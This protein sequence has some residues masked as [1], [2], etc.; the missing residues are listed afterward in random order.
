M[1][2]NEQ[3]TNLLYKKHM[4]YGDTRSSKEIFEETYRSYSKVYQ[5]KVLAYGNLIPT[6]DDPTLPVTI[7]QVKALTYANP[8]IHYD[9]SKI[10][11]FDLIKKCFKV[12]FTQISPNCDDAFVLLDES[13]KQIENVIPFDLF[14]DAYNYKLEDAD[15]NEI[16]YGLNDWSFDIDSSILTFYNGVPDNVSADKPPLFTFYQYVGPTGQKSYIDALFLDETATLQRGQ[17]V[18]DVTSQIKEFL[19]TNI[20]ETWFDDNGFNGGDT[21]EGLGLSFNKITPIVDA[22]TNDPIN[23]YD[24]RSNT[25]VVTLLSHITGTADG[26]SV[27]F[28]SEGLNGSTYTVSLE[29]GTHLYQFDHH[30]AVI[31]SETSQEATVEFSEGDAIK[32]VTLVKNLDTGDYDLYSTRDEKTIVFKFPVFVDLMRLPPSL[33]LND[34]NSYSDSLTPQYYGPRVKDVVIADDS[35]SIDNR[36]ADYIVYDT[37][38]STVSTVLEKADANARTFYLRN[39]TYTLGKLPSLDR[40]YV[41]EGESQNAVISAGTIDTSDFGSD[42]EIS[43][44]N[45]TFKEDV[46]INVS[47]SKVSFVNC[48]F[49]GNIVTDKEATVIVSHSI[50]AGYLEAND[51]TLT[52]DGGT[53]I[54]KLIFNG[55]EKGLLSVSDADIS[56]LLI[57]DPVVDGCIIDSTR[58][59]RVESKPKNVKLESSYVVEYSSNVDTTEIPNDQTL[60]FYRSFKERVY[61]KFQAPYHYDTD[62]NTFGLLIDTKYHTLFIDEETGE[63]RSRFYTDE[64]TSVT[65]TIKTQYQDHYNDHQ[66]TTL[67]LTDESG[68]YILNDNGNKI[69]RDPKNVKEAIEDL[70]WAKADLKN[71]KVPLQ[72]LPDSVAYGGLHF[73]GIW[74]F[75]QELSDDGETYNPGSYPTFADVDNRYSEDQEVDELQPGWFFIVD[76]SHDADHK[77]KDQVAVLQSG[78]TEP[79]VFTAGDWV[80]WDGAKWT[81]VDRAFQEVVYHLLP[82]LAPESKKWSYKDGGEGY[83]DFE[84]KTIYETIDLLN[85]AL[86]AFANHV[87]N[88]ITSISIDNITSGDKVAYNELK[89]DTTTYVDSISHLAYD[90]DKMSE[91]HFQSHRGSIEPFENCFYIGATY[92]EPIVAVDNVDG[93]LVAFNLDKFNPFTKWNVAVQGE[94]EGDIAAQFTIDVTGLSLDEGTYTKTIAKTVSVTWSVTSPDILPNGHTK[95]YYSGTTVDKD[96]QIEYRKFYRLDKVEFA[97]NGNGNADAIRSLLKTSQGISY[98]ESKPI[99]V[100]GEVSVKNAFGYGSVPAVTSLL[101]LFTVWSDNEDVSDISVTRVSLSKGTGDYVD[102]NVTWTATLTP[103]SK[104]KLYDKID[105][106]IKEA[107]FYDDVAECD[108]PIYEIRHIQFISSSLVDNAWDREP[109]GRVNAGYSPAPYL[110][111][112]SSVAETMTFGQDFDYTALVSDTAKGYELLYD[113]L[114]NCYKWPTKDINAIAFND[115]EDTLQ[116]DVDASSLDVITSTGGTVDIDERYLA[117]K[118]D[119]GQTLDLSGLMLKIEWTDNSLVKLS[120]TTGALED[121]TLRVAV[122]SD[123]LD[124][125]TTSISM[126]ANSPVE[127]YYPKCTFTDTTPLLHPGKSSIEHRRITFGRTPLPIRYV[128]VRAGISKSLANLGI[129]SISIEEA[130]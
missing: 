80:I 85:Q 2:K 24:D 9:V 58:I 73:V 23:G 119:L 94:D 28:A 66:D 59:G 68:N 98:L 69:P 48:H 62:T 70:Y 7:D 53:Y 122:A 42:Y 107:G 77:A 26:A 76:A 75:E 93:S 103:S 55:S 43:F 92:D 120:S 110:Y 11:G 130:I 83:Y 52:V 114:D 124:A 3:K 65:A 95:E 37:S 123:E 63:L 21:S 112:N 40:S 17:S 109:K 15:G 97:R 16:P 116:L 25:Q 81:K 82:S 29:E 99:T 49:E 61:A 71:G 4:G 31:T 30:L 102:A 78:E 106:Y 45:I 115:E 47:G 127:M 117:V 14:E 86:R 39:G 12:Q 57:T 8:I 1:L 91:A 74:S 89:T 41:V 108:S 60:V 67:Y 32:L 35:T 46:I 36:S 101:S 111:V 56:S 79:L 6:S 18:A 20:G 90:I 51:T 128:Y 34:F 44:I 126:N 54:G 27:D 88:P 100:S 125:S 84:G 121:V 118:F 129:K 72:Q 87:P 105:F 33:K 22:S 96:N 64:E 104:D 5:S 13:G 19:S 10:Y 113:V 50:V 38:T